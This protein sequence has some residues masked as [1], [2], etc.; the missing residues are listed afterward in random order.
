MDHWVNQCNAIV[1]KKWTAEWLSVMPWSAR[2][3][4][5]SDCV[6]PVSKKWTAKWISVM[7]LSQR[8]GLHFPSCDF[9]FLFSDDVAKALF[10]LFVNVCVSYGC[11]VCVKWCCFICAKRFLFTCLR[12]FCLTWMVLLFHLLAVFLFRPFDAIVSS[13]WNGCASSV[14]L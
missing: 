3:G 9:S 14:R 6:M 11:F 1:S 12:W 7:T 5:L 2:N 13:V 10:N 8:N 4:L